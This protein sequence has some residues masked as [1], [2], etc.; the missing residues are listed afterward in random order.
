MN[1]CDE[2][3]KRKQ[4]VQWIADPFQGDVY[5]TVVMRFLCGKCYG[6]LCDE[7]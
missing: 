5:N 6:M 2:C 3:G 4:S 1:K 7:I